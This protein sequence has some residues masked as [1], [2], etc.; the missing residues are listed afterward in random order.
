[1]ESKDAKY[2]QTPLSWEA[3][4]GQEAIVT[5]LLEKGADVKSKS[6]NGRTPLSW[7]AEFGRR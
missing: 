7:A 4:Y 1:V 3:E 2:G 5:L 6:P